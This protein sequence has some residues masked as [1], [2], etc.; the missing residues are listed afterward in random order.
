MT[1]ATVT[2]LRRSMVPMDSARTDA[3]AS[4][5]PVPRMTRACVSQLTGSTYIPLS[6]AML[7][8]TMTAMATAA[9]PSTNVTAPITAALAA[10][11]LPRRGDA[12]SVARMRPRRYSTVMNIAAMTTMMSSGTEIES[13][14]G[15]ARDPYTGIRAAMPTEGPLTDSGLEVWP[16]GIYD[17]VMQI[18]REYHHPVIEIT[19]SGCGYLDAPAGS[20]NGRIPDTRRIHWYRQVLAELARAIA[21]GARVRAYHRLPFG[22]CPG[23][24]GF[25]HARRGPLWRRRRR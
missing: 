13:D 23:G 25:R 5:A 8:P 10:S 3:S 11:S 20:D 9:D 24:T 19:E 14:S 15:S 7:L 17:L 21:D 2:T 4:I 1:A 16:R 12:A 18:S 22:I 6:C